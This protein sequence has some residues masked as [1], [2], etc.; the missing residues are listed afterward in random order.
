MMLEI[1]VVQG[2]ILEAEA[3]A[4]VNARLVLDWLPDCPGACDE[5]DRYAK[6][7]TLDGLKWS[8]HARRMI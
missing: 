3:E 8:D 2:S 1:A 4:I 5:K 6:V 7:L